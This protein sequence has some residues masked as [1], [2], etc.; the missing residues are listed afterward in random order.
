M[1]E[2]SA[3]VWAFFGIAFL[4]DW[5]ENWPF[6]VLWLLLSFPNLLAYW[7]QHF[8]S[9]HDKFKRHKRKEKDKNLDILKN[10]ILVFPGGANDKESACQCRRHK[11][12]RSD[13]QVK[14]ILWRRKLKAT[15]GFLLGESQE[16][17][18]RDMANYSLWDGKEGDAT[19]KTA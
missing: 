18:T 19:E 10:K 16:Q 7:V 1:C 2:M 17:R 11:R 15:L 14:K 12:W 13:P 4:R 5:N 6:P 3:I 9:G 8:H